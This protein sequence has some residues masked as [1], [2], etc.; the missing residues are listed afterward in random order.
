[1]KQTI[2]NGFELRSRAG[3]GFFSCKSRVINQDGDIQESLLTQQNTAF[4]ELLWLGPV[5]KF[6]IQLVL[7]ESI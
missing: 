5:Q 7:V 6:L 1:V 3:G 4:D 2:R